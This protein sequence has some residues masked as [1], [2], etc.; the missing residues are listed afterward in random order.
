VPSAPQLL[1]PVNGA[2]FE[3]YPRTTTLVWQAVPGAVSYLV[4]VEMQERP[5]EPWYSPTSYTVTVATVTF[6][7]VGAQPGRW[8]V[9]AQTAAGVWSSPSGWWVFNY[10]V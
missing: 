2:V 1:A 8:R 9:T 7:W 3:H 10:T 5:G 6:E 4:E